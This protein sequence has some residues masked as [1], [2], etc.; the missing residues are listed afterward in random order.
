[1]GLGKKRPGKKP[2][3]STK[4]GAPSDTKKDKAYDDEGFRGIVRIAGKDVSGHIPLRRALLQVRGM[5][6]T[7]SAAMAAAIHQN[8]GIAPSFKVGKLTDDQIEKIDAVLHSASKYNLPKYIFN[9]CSDTT[10]GT[11]SHLIMN[12]LLFA[13]K[14]DIEK[15]KKLYTWK[16]YRHAYGQKVRGQRTRNT[17]RTGMAVGVLRKAVLAAQ[18]AA[19]EEEK[20][21]GRAAAAAKPGEKPAAGAPKAEEKPVA[22][23]AGKPAAKPAAKPAGKKPAK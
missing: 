16:G 4:P 7:L 23:S 9:R 14:Q 21:G 2:F 5:G 8:L 11:S 19:K 13:W 10:E 15:E 6:H 22:K 18:K 1:M 3:K 12:D 20:P 17:G